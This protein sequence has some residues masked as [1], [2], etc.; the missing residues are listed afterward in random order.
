MYTARHQVFQQVLNPNGILSGSLGQAQHV[1]EARITHPDRH[2]HL[3]PARM[4]ATNVENEE[5]GALLHRHI[6]WDR[7]LRAFP[8]ALP[9]QA[10]LRHPNLLGGQRNTARRPPNM[11]TR[12]RR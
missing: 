9:T 5:L 3:M 1:L 10:R 6:R 2:D 11:T 7:H 8:A 4:D 12:P